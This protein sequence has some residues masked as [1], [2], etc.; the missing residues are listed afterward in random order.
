MSRSICLCLWETPVQIVFLPFLHLGGGGDVSDQGICRKNYFLCIHLAYQF[1]HFLLEL[2]SKRKLNFCLFNVQFC[3]FSCTLSVPLCLWVAHHRHS[4][5]GRR[6]GPF[7][8][9]L[10][11]QGLFP[12]ILYSFSTESRIQSQS[13]LQ[14]E[15]GEWGTRWLDTRQELQV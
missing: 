9:W 8:P 1:P 14:K 3:I 4:D 5:P 13:G 12:Y 2:Q 10:N 6:G 11:G 7:S 15:G